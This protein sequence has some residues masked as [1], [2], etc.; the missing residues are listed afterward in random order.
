MKD[1]LVAFSV[2]IILLDFLK[3]VVMLR[4]HQGIVR[5]LPSAWGGMRALPAKAGGII[6]S[7]SAKSPGHQGSLM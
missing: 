4:L 5:L 6:D 1:T 2:F 3:K 7:C